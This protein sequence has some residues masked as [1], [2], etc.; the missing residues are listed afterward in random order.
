M[1]ERPK[2]DSAWEPILRGDAAARATE[3]V[4]AIASELDGESVHRLPATRGGAWRALV[5]AYLAKETGDTKHAARASKMLETA[6]DDLANAK[7]AALYGGFTSV[8][9]LAVHLQR[10]LATGDVGA[11]QDEQEDP[12]AVLQCIVRNRHRHRR[13]HQ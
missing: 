12:W 9:W 3:I 6:I 13:R 4:T 10:E 1:S 7:S 5:Y 11:G 8:A 2:T